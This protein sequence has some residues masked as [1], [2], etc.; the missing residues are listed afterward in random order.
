MVTL[1]SSADGSD[2]L[3]KLVDLVDSDVPGD[4]LDRF[5]LGFCGVDDLLGPVLSIVWWVVAVAG[6][7]VAVKVEKTRCERVRTM[8]VAPGPTCN[9]ESGLRSCARRFCG[10]SHRAGAMG[11]DG[12][13]GSAIVG[14]CVANDRAVSDAPALY[15]Y[16]GR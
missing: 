2:T 16:H 12:R 1:R 15:R 4:D 7:A 8:C 9:S 13:R 5:H 11:R 3:V 14:A 6:V 10:G